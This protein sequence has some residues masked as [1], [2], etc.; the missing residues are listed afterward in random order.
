MRWYNMAILLK[1]AISKKKV[2][3]LSHFLSDYK[4]EELIYCR[5]A[6]G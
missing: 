3:N 4:I 2:L 5:G 6:M 1:K